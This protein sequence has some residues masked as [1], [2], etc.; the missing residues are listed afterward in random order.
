MV[1]SPAQIQVNAWVPS[2]WEKFLQ[3]SDDPDY[4]KAKGYYY[5]HQ[6][7]IEMGTGA[8]HAREDGFLAFAITLFGTL[9]GIPIQT[10][11]NCSYRKQ[12][13]GECQPDVSFYIDGRVSL[14]PKGSSVV[15][16]DQ[17]EP[18]DLIVEISDSTYSDDIGKKR[19]LY[20]DMQFIEYWVVNV[21]TAQITAF[22]IIKGGSV[23]ISKSM[24]LPELDL[25]ILAQALDPQY[26]SDH[27][28][29]GAWLMEQFRP[30]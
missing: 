25:A 30:Q 2:S 16:L 27:S 7:R 26:Q 11:S 15:D 19:L 9:R 21:K 10:L 23:R 13:V 22:Q 6:M 20:E 29:V 4:E 3:L 12:S 5:N 24:V 17:N 14:T 1:S 28:R 8:D 18:P